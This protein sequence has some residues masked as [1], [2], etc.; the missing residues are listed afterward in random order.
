MRFVA[1]G[2]DPRLILVLARLHTK[3]LWAVPG[4]ARVPVY[5]G[6]TLPFSV[7]ESMGAQAA[8]GGS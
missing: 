4:L 8:V 2:T 6:A 7:S 5:R 3:T 1:D